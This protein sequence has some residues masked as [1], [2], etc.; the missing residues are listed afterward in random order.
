MELRDEAHILHRRQPYA[1][2]FALFFL[3]R[4]A[5]WDGASGQSSFAAAVFT[6]RKRA[7]RAS[8]DAS[9][10][11][12]FEKVYIGLFDDDGSVEFFDVEKAPPR[13]QPPGE[14]NS[15]A[16]LIESMVSAVVVRNEGV[17]PESRYA[18]ERLDWSAPAFPEG[19][20]IEEPLDDVPSL[21]GED[22]DG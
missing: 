16:E 3:P 20:E 8:A 22:D 1:V 6:F 19:L 14:T 7:G 10:A 9:R 15:L 12:L 5:S 17:A 13:N 11:D 2:L 21:E 4:D 18:P